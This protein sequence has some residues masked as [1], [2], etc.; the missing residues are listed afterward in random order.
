L[1]GYKTIEWEKFD[2]LKEEFTPFVLGSTPSVYASIFLFNI[3]Y[4]ISILCAYTI[5][6]TF[7][8]RIQQDGQKLIFTE[9]IPHYD[10]GL[11]RCRAEP[12][13]PSRL[14]NQTVEFEVEVV[15]E[16][17]HTIIIYSIMYMCFTQ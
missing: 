7:S 5:K 12:L 6:N 13:D 15:G 3:S 16:F 14:A 10:E 1:A 11:Y 2:K 8:K 9:V 4:F 17:D